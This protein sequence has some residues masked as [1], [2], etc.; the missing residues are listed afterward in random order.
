MKL[1]E[2]K[3]RLMQMLS[4]HIIIQIKS[5]FLFRPLVKRVSYYDG[6]RVLNLWECV[7]GSYQ[8]AESKAQEQ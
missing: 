1:P 4:K 2:L 7:I 5:R 3:R 6:R 8:R